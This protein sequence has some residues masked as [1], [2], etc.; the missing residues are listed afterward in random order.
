MR[1]IRRR[2]AL[3]P[4]R[5]A[6]AAGGGAQ[7]GQ[8]AGGRAVAARGDACRHACVPRI[9]T[10]R[11]DHQLQNAAA[12]R[13]GARKEHTRPPASRGAPLADSPRTLRLY[14]ARSEMRFV[15][16]SPL[17]PQICGGTEDDE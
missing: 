14:G 16:H 11:A 8:R 1:G 17:V 7:D 5:D 6:A 4:R 3:R 2:G 13:T 10:Y 9:G 12:N 15:R